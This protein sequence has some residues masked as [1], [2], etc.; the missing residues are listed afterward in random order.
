MNTLI[1]A[2]KNHAYANYSKNGWDVVIECWSEEDIAKAIG[3]ARTS[4]GAIAAV[5]RSMVDY[6]FYGEDI[7]NS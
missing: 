2:V 6:H 5:R 3:K 7:K 1:E 4:K